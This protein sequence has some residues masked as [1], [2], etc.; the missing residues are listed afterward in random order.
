MIYT[1]SRTTKIVVFSIIAIAVVLFTFGYKEGKQFNEQQAK[2]EKI[3]EEKA[4][5]TNE[6]GFSF[7]DL[8]DDEHSK[9]EQNTPQGHE[10]EEDENEHLHGTYE[11]EDNP[12]ADYDENAEVE[13]P[14]LSDY[15]D[16]EQ[17]QNAKN[18]SEAFVSAIYPFDGHNP[19]RSVEKATDYTTDILKSQLTGKIPR[20]TDSYFS[21]ELNNIE[22]YEPFNPTDD[23]MNLRVRVE[24]K[25]FDKDGKKTK[26]EVAE[27]NMKLIS[28]DDTFK[29]DNYE[30]S[31]LTN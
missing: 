21:K 29:V 20:P 28:S 1:A 22:V 2:A 24:G 31:T 27:Y 17:I 25:V 8:E 4:E 19:S 16:Q 9:D 23:Y 26:E 12:T 13:M 15:F 3:A 18:V 5:K 6:G 7:S 11:Y 30:Y 10:L 14:Q